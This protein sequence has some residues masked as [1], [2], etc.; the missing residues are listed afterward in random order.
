MVHVLITGLDR[1]KQHA[2]IEEVSRRIQITSNTFF[3]REAFFAKPL[4]CLFLFFW[5]GKVEQIVMRKP[6]TGG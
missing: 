5:E 2:W 1:K 3:I 4:A 6:K